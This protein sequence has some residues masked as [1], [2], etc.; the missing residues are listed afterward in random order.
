VEWTLKSSVKHNRFISSAFAN[1]EPRKIKRPWGWGGICVQ[2]LVKR[3]CVNISWNEAIQRQVSNVQKE[4][5]S[6]DLSTEIGIN[7]DFALSFGCH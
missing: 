6:T 3:R 7:S 2:G 4:K 5:N 1:T